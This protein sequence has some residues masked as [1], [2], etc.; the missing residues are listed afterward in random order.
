MDRKKIISHSD[1]KLLE[2]DTGSL[3]PKTPHHGIYWLHFDYQDESRRRILLPP[4][5]RRVTLD[6]LLNFSMPQFP[7][8]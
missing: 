4:L 7:L 3:V 8:L 2:L 1:M 6:S 5:I